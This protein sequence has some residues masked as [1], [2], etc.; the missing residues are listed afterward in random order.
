MVKEKVK[1]GLVWVLYGLPVVFFVVCYFLIVT[2]GEDIYQGAGQEVDIIGDA[3]AAFQH[4]A[5]LADMWA[6]SIINLFDYTFKFGMD[7]V[8]RILDVAVA[9]AIFYL[10][11]AVA[12]G[13]KPKARLG[14]AAVFAALWLTV[15]L[16][17]NGYILYAGFSAIHNYLFICFFSTLYLGVVLRAILGRELMIKNKWVTGVVMGILGFIFGFA[18]NTTAVVFLFAMALYLGWKKY[19]KEKIRFSAWFG[20]S[21]V[22][23]TAAIGLIYGVGPGLGDY[24]TSAY[25]L[26]SYDYL[27]FSEI[28]ADLSG[29]AGRILGHIAVNLGRFFAPFVAVGAGVFLYAWAKVGSAGKVTRALK[30]SKRERDALLAIGLFC[31]MHV[32]VFS[33]MRYPTRVVLPAYLL[34]AAGMWFVVRRAVSGLGLATG[35][36]KLAVAGVMVALMIGLVGGRTALAIEY[37]TRVKPLLEQVRNAEETELCLGETETDSKLLPFIYLG[38]DRFLVEWATPEKIY[39]KDV[40]L[41]SE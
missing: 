27:A 17:P 41:C 24:T 4:S 10:N 25:Y 6:W 31:V 8:V 22:G 23:I 40:Y 15:F 29:S 36:A 13:R 35:R 18:S 14:D 21:L 9:W 1:Q 3:V 26:N 20:A 38:Q 12:L 19:K 11:T 37:L 34:G 32:L 5:R 2:S 33:Q 28:F 7:T 39:G 30:F 16:T